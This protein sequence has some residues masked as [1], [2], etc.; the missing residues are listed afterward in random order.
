M[1][2]GT[3]MAVCGGKSGGFLLFFNGEQEKE[4][5][6]FKLPA[7]ARDMD[8]HEASERVATVHYDRHLRVTHLYPKA[9]G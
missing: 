2:D 8:F 6:R 4:V 1:P 3:A 7:L 9:A 5:H